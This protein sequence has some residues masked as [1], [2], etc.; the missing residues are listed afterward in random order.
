VHD[1]ASL[2]AKLV[3]N[4]QRGFAIADQE[5]EVGLRSIAVAVAASGASPA[6]AINVAT[7]VARVSR[8]AIEQRILPAMRAAADTCRETVKMM[9]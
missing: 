2:R 7:N 4:R 9:P 1:G 6:F 8:A 5:L 3:D